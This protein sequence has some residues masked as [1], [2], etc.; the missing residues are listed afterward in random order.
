EWVTLF[1]VERMGA[2]SCEKLLE[3]KLSGQVFRRGALVRLV[4]EVEVPI[5]L[6]EVEYVE[7]EVI[8]ILER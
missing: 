1:E 2:T 3:E 7:V 8:R 5:R 6:E 4:N